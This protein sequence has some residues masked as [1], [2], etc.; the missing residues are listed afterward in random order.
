[1]FLDEMVRCLR[2]ADRRVFSYDFE[3]YYAP[4][5]IKQVYRTQIYEYFASFCAYLFNLVVDFCY[6]CAIIFAHILSKYPISL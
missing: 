2:D 1:M 4:K 6:F 5:L 3:A